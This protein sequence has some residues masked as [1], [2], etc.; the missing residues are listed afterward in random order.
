MLI[1][2][3]FVGHCEIVVNTCSNCVC[4]QEGV[5]QGS[6][7]VTSILRELNL[8]LVKSH[9]SRCVWVDCCVSYLVLVALSHEE[10]AGLVL[11]AA[12]STSSDTELL[13]MHDCWD[14]SSDIQREDIDVL[15]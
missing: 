14:P 13:E 6:A 9:I 12:D 7:L 5:P 10:S 3:S 8:L 15:L 4:L 11:I 2:I 1:I